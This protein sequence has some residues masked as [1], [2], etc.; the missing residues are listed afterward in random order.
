MAILFTCSPVAFLNII[1][2]MQKATRQLHSLCA[3]G[4]QTKDRNL[5]KE[6]PGIKKTLE[7]L[8]FKMKAMA[9]QVCAGGSGGSGGSGG[10]G[11]GSCSGSC[12][13]NNSNNS[14][15]YH[16]HCVP[17]VF[18]IHSHCVTP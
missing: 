9:A 11:S 6:I 7:V 4:K 12:A 18:L 2:T 3:H 1:K 5:A 14:S 13:Y 8:L 16:S 17:Y 10:G 15:M